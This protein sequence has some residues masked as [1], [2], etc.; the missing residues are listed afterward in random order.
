MSNCCGDVVF[1][2]HGYTLLQMTMGIIF[3]LEYSAISEARTR[4]SAALS[5]VSR[6]PMGEVS[7]TNP[8][9]SSCRLTDHQRHSLLAKQLFP[10]VMQ[11]SLLA[12]AYN[13]EKIWVSVLTQI[14]GVQP[15][16]N[17]SIL[18]LQFTTQKQ[19]KF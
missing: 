10:G 14:P 9:C 16:F 2:N 11:I 3:Y 17:P 15:L 12:F 13:I 7:F 19:V 4:P 8:I 6:L 1:L 5:T 18:S